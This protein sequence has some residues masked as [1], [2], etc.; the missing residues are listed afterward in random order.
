M[1][2][3][4]SVDASLL[5]VRGEGP[6]KLA[7]DFRQDDIHTALRLPNYNKAKK[8]PSSTTALCSASRYVEME[9]LAAKFNFTV[10]FGDFP[11]IC[12]CTTV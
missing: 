3:L 2:V 12:G 10:D 6:N 7:N 8:S 5:C 4:R 11:Q 9:F 1:V